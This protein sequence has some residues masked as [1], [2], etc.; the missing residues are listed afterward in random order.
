[1]MNNYKRLIPAM[2]A[3]VALTGCGAA[4]AASAGNGARQPALSAAA[5]VKDSTAGTTSTGGVPAGALPF[6]VAVGDTWVYRADTAVGG[7]TTSTIT[8][9]IIAVV[10]T[11]QGTRVT[12]SYANSIA[13]RTH[14][15]LT[16]VF[17]PNGTITFPLTQ[18]LGLQV[19]RSSGG[20]I[21]PSAAQAASGKPYHSSLTLT[22]A[23]D[24][25]QYTEV[26]HIT[27][28]GAGTQ[29]VAVP[30][31]TY[32][33]ATIIDGTFDMSLEGI[34]IDL[35]LKFWIANG[36]GEVKSEVATGSA[37]TATT[38]ELLSFTKG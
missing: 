33:N 37:T 11:S 22:F 18:N 27:M 30:A 16:W 12:E 36:T 8:N 25:K 20:I 35:R 17:H 38:L 24:G 15:D 29:T 19:V 26:A 7:G 4:A 6:P 5:A 14:Q 1:M 13:T 3:V 28:Q 9:K 31:G 21:L 23:E 32:Q 2:A 10:S 34:T